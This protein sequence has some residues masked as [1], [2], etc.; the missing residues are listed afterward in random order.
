MLM[1]Y[2]YVHYTDVI[3]RNRLL[4]LLRFTK[5]VNKEGYMFTNSVIYSCAL[6]IQV[7]VIT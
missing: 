2:V 3:N 7:S 5:N 4:L 6:F 1:K